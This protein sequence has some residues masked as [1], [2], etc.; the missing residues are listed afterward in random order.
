[1]SNKDPNISEM[2]VVNFLSKRKA[3]LMREINS[4]DE[5]ISSISQRENSPSF[6]Q[7]RTN[8]PSERSPKKNIEIPDTYSPDLKIDEKIFYAINK[9]VNPDREE[10]INY[11]LEK[12]P[13]LD[14]HKTS[15]NIVTRL[16]ILFKQNYLTAE[17]EGRRY[18]YGLP[19]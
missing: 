11:L 1:M 17:K 12:D 7:Q 5:I 18:R 2:E 10:I 4:I 6:K 14:E 16:S 9:L 15:R 19:K 13:K 3:T 8:E